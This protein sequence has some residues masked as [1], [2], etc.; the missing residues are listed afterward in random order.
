MSS[1]R[2]LEKIVIVDAVNHALHEEMARNEK[3]L[4]YGE[5]VADGKGGVFTATKGLSTAFGNKRVF[6]SPLAEASIVGTAIGLSI[7]GYKPVVEIQFG[8]YIWPAVMQIRDELTMLRY[9]TDGDFSCPVVIRVA[10]GGYI[11]GGL[12]HSQS[13]EG[14]LRTCREFGLHF[15]QTPP[16]QK[17]FK[18]QFAK[19]ILFYFASIKVCID[20]NLRH[21]TSQMKII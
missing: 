5:D 20:N 15:H 10:V 2:I 4:I 8:D 14:F 17:D 11:R 7:Y 9:R 21:H 18:L 13:I 1:H 19:T 6:N 12:Y 16:M 3:I